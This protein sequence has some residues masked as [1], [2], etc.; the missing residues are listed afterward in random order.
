[1]KNNAKLALILLLL[2]PFL[3]A[4]QG[5]IE[6]SAKK[7]NPASGQ[8][9]LS[10]DY[11]RVKVNTNETSCSGTDGI[12]TVSQVMA[13]L[14]KTVTYRKSGYAT[15]T[16]TITVQNNL[17]TH[18]DEICLEYDDPITS[19]RGVVSWGTQYG[20]PV[21]ILVE[22][23]ELVPSCGGTTETLR[24]SVKTCPD[25]KYSFPNL[26]GNNVTY[27]VKASFTGCTFSPA[28]YDVVIPQVD[29][30]TS[31]NFSGCQ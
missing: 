22:V 16:K 31:Y 7:K 13:G 3:S 2:I 6:G 23:Y 26:S 9:D 24:D 29:E 25:G 17:T 27:R 4:C 10:G 30:N 28:S 12:Y 5:N 1:M 21:D 20:P 19:V 8:C 15:Q 14:S 11:I 18:V